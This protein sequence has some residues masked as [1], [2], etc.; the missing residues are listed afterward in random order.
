MADVKPYVR[1]ENLNVDG[2][3]P[4]F[5]AMLWSNKT[6]WLA[7]VRFELVPIASS[8]KVEARSINDSGVP[9]TE[10]AT[11]WGFGF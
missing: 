10:V 4:F 8:L 3:D 6:I 2:T 7:G 9:S 5:N 1:V 11:A